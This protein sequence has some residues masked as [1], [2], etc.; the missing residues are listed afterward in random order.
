MTKNN[1]D[2]TFKSPFSKRFIKRA[3]ELFYENILKVGTTVFDANKLNLNADIGRRVTVKT[4]LV[5]EDNVRINDGCS[6]V[7]SKIKIGRGSNI[8]HDVEIVGPVN[9]GRYCAIARK[10]L[11]Q[12]H[13]HTTSRAA[14]QTWIY[15]RL[16][17]SSL[18]REDK[19]GINIENDVW[20]GTRSIILPGVTIGDGAIVGAGSVVTR[21]VAPYSITGGAP[22]VHKKNRFSQK[23]IERLMHI[24]WWNWSEE[25]ISQ[26]REFFLIDL[27]SH[28]DPWS[29]I[30]D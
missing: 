19:N 3:A 4:K 8:M 20:I 21:D 7:G 25:K 22:A 27:D 15:S 12:G 29:L 10:S 1:F 26:N 5:L 28:L 13:N 9:I 16:L 6:L 17:D 30:N 2:D 24:Q 23:T 14:Q 11:F 18:P